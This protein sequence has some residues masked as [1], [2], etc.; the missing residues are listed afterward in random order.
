VF[1]D[2][3]KQIGAAAD[4]FFTSPI[5]QT[6]I[7]VFWVLLVALYA[8]STY[9]VWRDSRAR[10]ANR[11]VPYLFA[12]I[13]LLSTPILFVGV[14]IMYKIMRPPETLDEAD[15]RGLSRDVLRAEAEDVRYCRCGSRVER[16]WVICPWCRTRLNRVCPNCHQLVGMDWTLCAWC[17]SEFP[18]HRLIAPPP[19]PNPPAVEDISAGEHDVNEPP[20]TAPLS[21]RSRRAPRA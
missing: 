5:I 2:I 3:L 20:A 4:A 21:V 6:T 1:S 13:V 19:D 10:V 11:Y 14:L 9:W 17:G 12:S 15:E 18:S 16:E 8:A 7:F